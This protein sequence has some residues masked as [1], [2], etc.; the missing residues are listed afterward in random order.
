MI[1]EESCDQSPVPSPTAA[2]SLIPSPVTLELSPENSSEKEPPAE[3]PQTPVSVSNQPADKTPERADN[4][5]DSDS[6]SEEVEELVIPNSAAVSEL[7]SS[8]APDSSAPGL[9]PRSRFGLSPILIPGV[10]PFF[11]L[12]VPESEIKKEILAS[13]ALAEHHPEHNPEY[14]SESNALPKLHFCEQAKVYDVEKTLA[15][16]PLITPMIHA[17]FIQAVCKGNI[18]AVQEYLDLPHDPDMQ[19]PQCDTALVLAARF[20]YLPIAALLLSYYASVN[21]PGKDQQ[22]ALCWA[23]RNENKEMIK[24]LVVY[25]ARV[26][27]WSLFETQ[28]R[29]ADPTF[30]E[31]QMAAFKLLIESTQAQ[32]AHLE[33]QQ[34]LELQNQKIQEQTKLEELCGLMASIDLCLALVNSEASDCALGAG[35]SQVTIVPSFAQWLQSQELKTADQEL[36]TPAVQSGAASTVDPREQRRALTVDTGASLETGFISWGECSLTNA[37]NTSSSGTENRSARTYLQSPTRGRRVAPG[38][39]SRPYFPSSQYKRARGRK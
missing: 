18:D 34:R 28:L 5:S 12:P 37:D 8:R 7:A 13:S 39:S 6:D 16:R 30:T 35:R 27:D 22:T 14:N 21:K 36:K 1:K 19:L 33:E 29:N 25:G 31:N 32:Q 24:L 38:A 3:P 9:S 17:S 15:K 10:D 2:S 11:D 4:T 23:V 26:E 20:N